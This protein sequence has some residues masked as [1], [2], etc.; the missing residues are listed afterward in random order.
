M[1]PKCGLQHE[2]LNEFD[3]I[4]VKEMCV[5]IVA[6]VVWIGEMI[7]TKFAGFPRVDAHCLGH[8]VQPCESSVG[9]S[10]VADG[11]HC[12]APEELVDC[13]SAQVVQDAL[14]R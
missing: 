5:T 2:K 8:F 12:R 1:F 13:S 6:K 14:V 3:R 7:V 11:C 4:A 10:E 9:Q